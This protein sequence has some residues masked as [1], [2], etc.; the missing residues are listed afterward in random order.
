MKPA[1]M[2]HHLKGQRTL[3]TLT[4]GLYSCLSPL[5]LPLAIVRLGHR[6]KSLL[7]HG[8]HRTENRGILL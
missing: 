7:G 6:T 3:A 2:T 4:S 5:T 1:Q 8:P